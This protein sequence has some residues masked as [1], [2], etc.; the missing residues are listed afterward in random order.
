MTAFNQQR[1]YVQAV[2]RP[3]GPPRVEIGCRPPVLY[4]KSLL[5]NTPRMKPFPA[6][7]RGIRQGR[8]EQLSTVNTPLT[9]SAIVK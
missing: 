6:S 8:T 9:I 5:A 4:E 3:L 7:G 2:I 1:F